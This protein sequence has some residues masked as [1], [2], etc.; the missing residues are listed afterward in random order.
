MT[1]KELKKII[2]EKRFVL[3][4]NNY[5]FLYED[6]AFLVNSYIDKIIADYDLVRIDVNNLS[7]IIDIENNVFEDTS[8]NLYIMTCDSFEDDLSKYNFKNLIIK[9]KKVTNENSQEL[10][11]KFDK[12]L[13]WQIEDYVKASLPGLT[14]SEVKWLCSIAK[15]DVNRLD[16]ECKKINIFDKK[17]QESIFK[18]LN[19]E[20]MY[21]DL[22]AL[23]IFNFTNA[24]LRNNLSG[25][26]DVLVDIANI[27]VEPTGLVTILYKNFKNIINIQMSA[28]ATP[29]S[30]KMSPKQ[31]A[32]IKRNCNVYNNDN[33]IR[34]F[35]ILTSIDYRLKSGLL[36]NNKIIDYLITHIM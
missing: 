24:I 23:T 36:D 13:D 8:R 2:L 19:N 18:Q 27:D 31:F 28:R 35:N 15:Y 5:I 29:E 22:N 11:I 33:L 17:D 25:A 20:N 12:L 9:T 10:V 34:I 1:L 7:E 21:E 16:L 6:T 3:N 26:K 30:L 4:L 14:D 32:A